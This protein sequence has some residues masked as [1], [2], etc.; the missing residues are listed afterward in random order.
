MKIST[1]RVARLAGVLASNA[2][3][4]SMDDNRCRIYGDEGYLAGCL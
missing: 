2:I 4:I 3:A 1:D